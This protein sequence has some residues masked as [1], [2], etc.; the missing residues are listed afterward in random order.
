MIRTKA[1]SNQTPDQTIMAKG[2]IPQLLGLQTS[3]IGPLWFYWDPNSIP[4]PENL[5]PAKKGLGRFVNP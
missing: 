3:R 1:C 2:Q 5:T 4:K